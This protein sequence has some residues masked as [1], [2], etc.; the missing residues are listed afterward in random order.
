[1]QQKYAIL[2]G[3]I[4][5]TLAG[6]TS[7]AERRQRVVHA[8]AAMICEGGFLNAPQVQKEH[9]NALKQA[10]NRNELVAADRAALVPQVNAALAGAGIE[11]ADINAFSAGI[12][13]NANRGPLVDAMASEVNKQCPNLYLDQNEAVQYAIATLIVVYAD[14]S[15]VRQ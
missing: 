3:I 7:D 1:M 5:M 2:V 4:L 8:M 10:P 11:E 12:N 14:P 13:E 9:V 6:C 15:L